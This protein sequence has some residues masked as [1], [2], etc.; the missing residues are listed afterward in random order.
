MP[1]E[2]LA[3]RARFTV[4]VDE[5]LL[6]RFDELTRREGFATRSEAIMDCMR[7]RAVEKEWAAGKEVAGAIGLV[8]DHHRRALVSRLMDIQHDFG[9]VIV[10]TQHIHLDHD[11]C[12]ELVVVKGPA[13]K[14]R[15]LVERF[16]SVKGLKHNE[17][18]MTTT[19]RL[20]G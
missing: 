8:Y 20:S 19:G 12:L 10:C 14:I 4:S 18:M 16:K 11:N 1:E 5:H 3:R 17:L 9:G 13:E 15:A 7:R 2:P 6:E